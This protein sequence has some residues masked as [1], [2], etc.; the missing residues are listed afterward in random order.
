MKKVTLLL[1][2]FGLVPAAY[3]YEPGW[4]A[5]TFYEAVN[6]CRASIAYPAATDYKNRGVE[7]GKPEGEMHE[8]SL[9][10]MPVFDA[11]ATKGCFCTINEVA[12]DHVPSDYPNKVDLEQYMKVPRCQKALAQPMKEIMGDPKQMMEMRLK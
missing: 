9:R 10:M 7:K 6:H 8:E 5:Q 3:G 4:S 1:I 11:V 2:I 12:K